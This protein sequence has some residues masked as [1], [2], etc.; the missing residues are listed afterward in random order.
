MSDKKKDGL[1]EGFVPQKLPKKP[2]EIE[3]GFVP[4]PPPKKPP[5]PPPKKPPTKP[6]NENK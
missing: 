3:K 4:P 6:S 5:P 1:K 2:K